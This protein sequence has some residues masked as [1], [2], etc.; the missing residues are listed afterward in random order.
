M[1]DG[2]QL[3]SAGL[4]YAVSSS[5]F[6]GCSRA[7]NNIVQHE[8]YHT[9]KKDGW[10]APKLPCV[11]EPKF[12]VWGRR[13][14][15]STNMYLHFISSIILS[16]SAK[17]TTS[18]FTP[19]TPK[20]RQDWGLFSREST[21]RGDDQPN[22]LLGSPKSTSDLSRRGTMHSRIRSDKWCDKSVGRVGGR[23]GINSGIA[24]VELYMYRGWSV[25]NT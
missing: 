20:N 15:T 5:L 1:I 22:A 9:S 25:L 19:R 7:C 16:T 10:G 23:G 4:P 3:E 6:G 14:S 24:A 12:L 18:V 11:Y 21:S 2:D 13:S 8:S 17:I